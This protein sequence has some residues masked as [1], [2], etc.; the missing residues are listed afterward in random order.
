MSMLGPT[1]QT[2]DMKMCQELEWHPWTQS[3]IVGG[4][5]IHFNVRAIFSTLQ[6]QQIQQWIAR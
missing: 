2:Q 3:S 4:G 6:Q 1:Y 5:T